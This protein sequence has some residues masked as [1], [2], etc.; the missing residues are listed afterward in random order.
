MWDP[1]DSS[2]YSSR[3]LTWIRTLLVNFECKLFL[4]SLLEW[5][6]DVTFNVVAF[7]FSVVFWS[8]KLMWSSVCKASII[9]L[10]QGNCSLFSEITFKEVGIWFILVSYMTLN[11]C[12]II[13]SYPRFLFEIIFRENSNISN[14]SY[15]TNLWK[16]ILIQDLLLGQSEID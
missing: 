13:L 15:I 8:I 4:Q 1:A 10:F 11:R 2:R 14:S 6:L 12:R 16:N 5:L 7:T 3:R 9:W